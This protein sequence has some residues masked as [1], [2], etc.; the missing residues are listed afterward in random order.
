TTSHYRN[1]HFSLPCIF[2]SFYGNESK[3]YSNDQN[4][5]PHIYICKITGRIK[6]H[7][8][9]FLLL[10]RSRERESKKAASNARVQEHRKKIYSDPKKLEEYRRKE[11]ER[12]KKRKENGLLKSV[13]DMTLME[14]KN[15]SRRNG[16]RILPDTLPKKIS[17]DDAGAHTT[18]R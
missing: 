14:K 12:Y 7:N 3:C 2:L 9:N 11:R 6:L 13:T 8:H 17:Q 10:Q 5:I 16:E 15:I 18:I 4:C 1:T